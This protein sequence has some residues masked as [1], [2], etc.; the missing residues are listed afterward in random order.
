MRSCIAGA[1][2]LLA[3]TPAAWAGFS[4]ETVEA[5][6][7][8]LARAAY[9]PPGDVLAPALAQL[10]HARYGMIRYRADARLWAH[11]ASPF[12]IG[13]FING[14]DYPDPV[15]INEVDTGG[16]HAV[17]FDPGNFDLGQS[18]LDA[19]ALAT[20]GF[21][22]LAVHVRSPGKNAAH[23]TQ[24]VLVFQGATLFSGHGFGQVRGAG[25]R[26]LA[27]DTGLLS[28]EEF[29]RF[30][31]FW[32]E[33]PANGDTTLV[34]DA[35]M[36]SKRATGAYRFVVT[37]GKTL[38][39]EVRARIFLRGYVTLLGVAPINSMYLYGENDDA[40]GDGDY[41]PEVHDSDGLQ[42]HSGTGEW[43]WRPLVNPARLLTTSFAMTNPQ[44]FG[45]MQRDRQFSDYEDLRVRYDRKPSVWV[46]P[47]SAWGAGRVELV[48]LPTPDQTHTNIVAFW[49]PDAPPKP[50]QPLDLAYRVEWQGDD[51]THPPSAWAVQTRTGHG[52]STH[53]QS[54]AQFVVDFVG[55]A[56]QR[57]APDTPLTSVVSVDPNGQVL[58][59]RVVYN[60]ATDGWRLFLRIKR[61]DDGKPVEMRAYL[62]NGNDTVSETWSYILPP[63]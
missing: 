7:Q 17:R 59:Q 37:P 55:S 45:L 58:E 46:T 33:R 30:T 12:S 6:A 2:L 27:I 21:S 38:K 16:V 20:A 56:L 36:D 11:T 13:F 3:C 40:H 62:R 43:I 29:P 49:A 44:G 50:G 61:Q 42:I 8:V 9:K 41:R 19:K 39:V 15:K 51:Q 63:S 23:P 1:L 34:I 52:F 14:N 32:I 4:F 26:G 57:L 48:E 47:E 31:K 10:D 5:A 35:L 18:K 24:R 54:G 25:A 22:G 53:P 28:G 60:A